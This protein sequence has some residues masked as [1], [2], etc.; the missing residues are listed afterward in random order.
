MKLVQTINLRARM[1]DVSPKKKA[2]RCIKQIKQL[3]I[4]A[5]KIDDVVIGED[6]NLFVW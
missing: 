6:V 4:R 2:P 1:V 5:T 3:A